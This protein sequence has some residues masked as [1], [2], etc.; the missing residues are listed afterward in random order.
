MRTLLV[1][2]LAAA[3][4][5][6]GGS[7]PVARGRDL[8]VHTWTPDDPWARGGDGVGP[9]FNASSCVACH[10]QAGVGGAGPAHLNVRL[11]DGAVQPLRAPTVT[12]DR[13]LDRALAR[14]A[15]VQ[16]GLVP[17]RDGGG[18]L[19]LRGVGG[20][21]AREA[22]NDAKR[23]HV[24]ATRRGAVGAAMNAPTPDDGDAPQR[25]R[26]PTFGQRNAPALFGAGLLD[27]I[28]DDAIE[29]GAVTRVD[30]P[31]ISGRVARTPEG[32]VARFGWKGDVADLHAFVTRA[33]A[34]EVGLEVPGA[35]QLPTADGVRAPAYDL[36]LDDVV[37][38]TSFVASL[39]R[40]QRQTEDATSA[41]GAR[42]FEAIG[43]A[44]CHVERVGDVDGLYSDLL[45]HDLGE[46]LADGSFAYGAE[47]PPEG[48]REW[49]TT[50]LWGVR[51]SGPWLHDGRADTLHAAIALHG[52]E[53]QA[54][55]D[56]WRA[57][58]PRDQDALVAFLETLA[59]PGAVPDGA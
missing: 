48:E 37:A 22:T 18:G 36:P 17:P 44:A 42:V 50:P 49:R 1:V 7:D 56:R 10:Q 33:C 14:S 11:V 40:P 54:T 52:G 45:L 41:H 24:E 43:C 8:F 25:R 35:S 15:L 5:A 9:V 51:D 59:A 4:A 34:V 12:V 27:G 57:L 23:A 26:P 2:A 47:G 31:E 6:A 58:A 13:D 53:A 30:F 32:R 55:T 21:P 39:P 3:S 46:H 19:G 38:L 20:S 29:A 16:L 28:D